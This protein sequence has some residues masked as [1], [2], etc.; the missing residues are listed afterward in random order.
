MAIGIPRKDIDK[1]LLTEDGGIRYRSINQFIHA[2]SHMNGGQILLESYD[3]WLRGSFVGPH[4]P[5]VHIIDE[6]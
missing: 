5:S 6:D 3:K 1:S 2:A 4:D